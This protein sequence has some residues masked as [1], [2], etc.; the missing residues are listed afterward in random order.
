MRLT[1]ISIA[2]SMLAL[3]ASEFLA[4]LAGRRIDPE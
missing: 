4:Y 2:I 3:L 1:L